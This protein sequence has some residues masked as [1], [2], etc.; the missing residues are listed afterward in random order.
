MQRV[1]ATALPHGRHRSN[2]L[3]PT[4]PSAVVSVAKVPPAT[5]AFVPGA[6]YRNAESVPFPLPVTITLLSPATSPL[7]VLMNVSTV[8]VSEPIVRVSAVGVLTKTPP[9]FETKFAW[10]VPPPDSNTAIER[11]PTDEVTKL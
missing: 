6:S 3:T 4:V 10:S 7:G 8:I 9:P 11:N 2:S 5:R 1:G